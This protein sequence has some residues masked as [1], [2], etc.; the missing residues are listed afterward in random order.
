MCLTTTH[1]WNECL[2]MHFSVHFQ[3]L[4]K[5]STIITHLLSIWDLP[6][7]W[8][9]NCFQ[10]LSVK[11]SDEWTCIEG[12]IMSVMWNTTCLTYLSSQEM[13]AS[14]FQL[15]SYNYDQYHFKQRCLKF[16]YFYF[17]ISYRI[18]E[19]ADIECSITSYLPL[20]WRFPSFCMWPRYLQRTNTRMSKINLF[21][22]NI[23]DTKE[24]GLSEVIRLPLLWVEV[25]FLLL[26]RYW[27]F[28]EASKALEILPQ[29]PNC[30]YGNN[31]SYLFIS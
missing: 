11:S 15:Y 29:K 21:I 5:L 23:Y 6:R 26:R 24:Q 7:V 28:H 10:L 30:M 19:E 18:R 8:C 3:Y 20:T 1:P 25:I 31:L 13:L 9:G 22:S 12:L 27:T 4:W 17:N 2:F 16:N 14:N